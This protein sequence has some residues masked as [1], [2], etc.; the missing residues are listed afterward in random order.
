MW[1][2]MIST[3]DKMIFR[4]F[5]SC[6]IYGIELMFFFASQTN[7][8]EPPFNVIPFKAAPGLRFNFNDPKSVMRILN[9]FHLRFSSV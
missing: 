7:T 6:R 9:F 1:W 8:G 3:G 5:V 4:L 2:W